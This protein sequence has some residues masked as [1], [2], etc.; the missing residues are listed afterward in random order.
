M[1]RRKK[2]TTGK[3][4]IATPF[5]PMTEIL[6]NFLSTLP[7]LLAFTLGAGVVMGILGGLIS[8]KLTKR[9]MVP[10]LAV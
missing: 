9:T 1:G 6:P 2:K 10:R 3:P 4:L 7:A 5:N 8:L